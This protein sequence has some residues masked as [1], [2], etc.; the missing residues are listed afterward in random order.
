VAW[1]LEAEEGVDV[2][3]VGDDVGAGCVAAALAI[4]LKRRGIRARAVWMIDSIEH[5]V[6]GLTHFEGH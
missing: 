6:S 3:I 5:I 2:D 4:V 1:G